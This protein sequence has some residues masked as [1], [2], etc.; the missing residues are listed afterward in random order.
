MNG[1]PPFYTKIEWSLHCLSSLSVMI[2]WSLCMN[3][4]FISMVSCFQLF[5][6]SSTNQFISA[7]VV[8]NAVQADVK[9]NWM[10][11]CTYPSNLR[12]WI[13]IY[14]IFVLLVAIS[15]DTWKAWGLKPVSAES[16]HK[17]NAKNEWMECFINVFCTLW[18][19]WSEIYGFL[20]VMKIVYIFEVNKLHTLGMYDRFQLGSF[21]VNAVLFYYRA[22][23]DVFC[24]AFKTGISFTTWTADQLNL[25]RTLNCCTRRSLCCLQICFRPAPRKW[26]RWRSKYLFSVHNRWLK[27]F[28]PG[29]FGF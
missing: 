14:S 18:R 1:C 15:N 9:G 22:R 5:W 24:H 19:F 4:N 25:G 11:S 21:V 8:F 6:R 17:K 3:V 20:H 29:C 27:L 10:Q 23:L 26:T 7:I 16:V 28:A 13:Y 2:R 12:R